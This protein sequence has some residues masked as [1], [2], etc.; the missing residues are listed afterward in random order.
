MISAGFILA[1][2]LISCEKQ[3]K[4]SPDFPG[5]GAVKAV[6]L[7][8]DLPGPVSDL[9]IDPVIIDGEN[10]GGN[11]TCE[12]V[13]M[14][15]GDPEAVCGVDYLCGEK[16]DYDEDGGGFESDFPDGLHVTVEGVHISFWAD[17]CLEIDGTFWKVGAVIVKGSNAANIYW[18]GEEEGGGVLADEGL[19]APGGKRMVSNLTFCLVPCEP[20]DEEPELI[21][22][23]KTG[24]RIY[25]G[26]TV[27]AQSYA[28]TAGDYPVPEDNGTPIPIGYHFLGF[29]DDF[30]LTLKQADGGGD[31]GT[32]VATEVDVA[33][34]PHIQV[35]VTITDGSWTIW[36]P[37]LYIGSEEGIDALFYELYPF[38]EDDATIVD[39]VATFMIPV[40]DITL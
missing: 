31:A 29:G 15:L 14:A 33:G 9:G 16:V 4:D 40:A 20:D 17:D 37:W 25:D 21:I 6:Y 22:S 10:K 5:Q 7:P 1:L 35:V 19:A 23:L 30:T 38:D 11:R 3:D 24:I 8:G 18:Y 28:Y 12:E 26:E 34:V 32:V 39:N 2:G 27:V 36:S 13:W